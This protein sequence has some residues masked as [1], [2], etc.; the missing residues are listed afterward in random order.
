MK[1]SGWMCALAVV[2]SGAAEAQAQLFFPGAGLGYVY[3]GRLG[4]GFHRRHLAFGGFAGYAGYGVNPYGVGLY[5]PLPLGVTRVTIITPPAVVVAPPRRLLRAADDDDDLSGVDLDVV[6]P[7][8]TPR[9]KPVPPAPAK[10][11]PPP[12]APNLPGVDVSVP[13]KPVRPGDVPPPP[14][15]KKEMSQPPPQ[16]EPPALPPPKQNP[17][18]EC[19]RLMDIGVTAFQMH[20]YGVAA[21]R[22]RQ[23]R[24][25]NPKEARAYF[26]SSEAD[27]ALGK[28]R[29]AVQAIHQGMR[30]HADWPNQKMQPRKDLYKDHPDFAEHLKRLED[31]VAKQPE[32]AD[33]LFLLAHALWFDGQRDRALMLFRRAKQLAADPTFLDKFLQAAAAG[34]VA[35]K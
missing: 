10:P 35:A 18:E 16:P 31:T 17:I 11:A 2:L 7:D 23:A 32:D 20:L 3:G 9:A 1:G 30:L 19:A 27:L 6:C 25:A 21:Q 13:K 34:Q 14:P 4:F 5:G 29:Q 8:G 33:F 28:Y 24:A 12:P 26:L 15:P 22:F